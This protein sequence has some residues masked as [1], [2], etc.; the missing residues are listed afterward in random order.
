MVGTVTAACRCVSC[1][2]VHVFVCVLYVLCDLCAFVCVYLCVCP[3]C[4]MCLVLPCVCVRVLCD[5]VWISAETWLSAFSYCSIL[6]RALNGGTAE[7]FKTAALAAGVTDDEWKLFAAFAATFYSNMGNYKVGTRH[8]PP[9]PF[10]S[11]WYRAAFD[12]THQS[13]HA[14]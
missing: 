13:L 5:C 14:L 12:T 10:A 1:H 6:Q 3:V 4:P 9:S 2:C 11:C 8:H 7:A